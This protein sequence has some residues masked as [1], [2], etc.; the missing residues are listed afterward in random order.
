MK[1]KRSIIETSIHIHFS[2]LAHEKGRREKAKGKNRSPKRML[3][4]LDVI[5]HLMIIIFLWVV[6]MMGLLLLV[7]DSGC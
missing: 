2:K 4:L 6:T 7:E 1:N 3:R 5:H